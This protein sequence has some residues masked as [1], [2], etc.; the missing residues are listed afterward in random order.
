M[1]IHLMFTL[2]F[3]CFSQVS[4]IY[5]ENL[6]GQLN[7]YTLVLGL[8][9]IFMMS[10]SMFLQVICDILLATQLVRNE[11]VDKIFKIVSDPIEVMS[12]IV[13]SIW[14]LS[15]GM[16]MIQNHYYILGVITLI[17][18]LLIIYYFN[19]LINYY[20]KQN[21]GIRP[22]TVFINGETFLIFAILFIGILVILIFQAD[23]KIYRPENEKYRPIKIIIDPKTR[24][25]DR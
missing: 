8:L 4:I 5:F 1:L 21:R 10:V 9:F 25:T 19:I 6:N 20:T 3:I 7:V 23:K 11:I 13:K 22:N 24:N 17:W 12:H 14:L 15:L 18:G 2:I 16:L